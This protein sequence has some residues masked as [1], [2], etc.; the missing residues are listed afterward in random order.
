MPSVTI[1]CFECK[2]NNCCSELM[3]L[4]KMHGVDFDADVLWVWTFECQTS[5]Q[6][7]EL[8]NCPVGILLIFELQ[9]GLLYL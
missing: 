1:A 6:V 7:M 8:Q 4:W 5:C 3:Y 9:F 2:L